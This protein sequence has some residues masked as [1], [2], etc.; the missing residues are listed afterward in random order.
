MLKRDFKVILDQ[1]FFKDE[2]DNLAGNCANK[3]TTKRIPNYFIL[4]SSF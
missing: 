4:D 3:L 2:K 1:V